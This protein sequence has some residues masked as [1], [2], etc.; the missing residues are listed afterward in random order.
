MRTMCYIFIEIWV[1]FWNLTSVLLMA[2]LKERQTEGAVIRE[3]QCEEV[4][5]RK[6]EGSLMRREQHVQ[7]P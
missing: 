2:A 4:F 7:G 3:S 1:F 6:L 5:Q